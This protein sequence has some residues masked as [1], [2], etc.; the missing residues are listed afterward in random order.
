[1]TVSLRNFSKLLS[2]VTPLGALLLIS[3]SLVGGCSEETQ[4]ECAGK[5]QADGSCVERCDTSKCP[6]TYRCLFGACAPPCD[7]VTD[8]AVGR[9]C[10]S[11]KTDDGA[12]GKFCAT[13]RDWEDG[14]TGQF[15]SCTSDKDCDTYRGFGCVD[16]QCVVEGCRDSEDCGELGQCRPGKKPDGGDT[17]WCDKDATA[18]VDGDPCKANTD[19]DEL[20][21][22][23]CADGACRVPSHCQTHADC[24]GIGQ[25]V[26]GADP[27][28]N[29]ARYCD[30]DKDAMNGE[31]QFGWPC[32]SGTSADCDEDNGFVCISAGEGDSDAYCTQ[33]DCLKDDDCGAG[34]RCALTRSATRPCNDQCGF[35]GAGGSDCAADADIGSGKKFE[36][37]PLGLLTRLCLKR[38]FCAE[39]E[40]DADCLGAPNQ[41][42]AK[43]KS[44][45]K[46]CTS[47]CDKSVKNACPWKADAE[48][49]DFDSDLG[50]PTCSHRFG[51][52][53]GTG[54]GC[55]PCIDD[56]DCPG[57]LCLS[58]GFSPASYCVDMRVSCTCT[59]GDDFCTSADCPDAPSGRAL[60]CL[61]GSDVTSSALYQTC[62]GAEVGTL[63]TPKRGCWPAQ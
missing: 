50:Q 9:F 2:Q 55:E 37:G 54:L 17:T 31:G 14:Q 18:S 29:E 21:G 12:T 61:G 15:E 8:C 19:C 32:L 11:V 40:T 43:D 52:C 26:V 49:G 42:C 10:A 23:V 7:V 59:V 6:D 58:T 38:E 27:D 60:Q 1:M 48:C 57:G 4:T 46:I 20:G 33:R 51:Q 44:G 5:K 35:T 45:T 22:Q 39:C 28:G 56:G 63:S 13:P 47:L 3:A 25:C 62:F 16:D 36:C 53:K 30:P 24:A 41:V 34:Y